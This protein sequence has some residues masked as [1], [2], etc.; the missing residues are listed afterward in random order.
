MNLVKNVN[1]LGLSPENL[2]LLEQRAQLHRRYSSIEFKVLECTPEKV[3]VRV[4]QDK[5]HAGNYFDQKRLVEIVRE[6][7][8]DLGGWS[9]VLARPIPYEPP[10]TEVVTPDWIKKKMDERGIKVKDLSAAL[11]VDAATISA[12]KNGV[13]PL[14]GVVRAMFYYYFSR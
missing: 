11:G 3:V 6:T 9:T 10:P 13:K 14:S 8:A 5:S 1:L 12:Y 2:A 4:V 7:F